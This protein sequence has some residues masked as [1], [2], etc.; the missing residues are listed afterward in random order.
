M[1]AHDAPT[2]LR[3]TSCSR[4]AFSLLQPLYF[5]LYSSLLKNWQNM[6]DNEQKERDFCLL[7]EHFSST[8]LVRWGVEWGHEPWRAFARVGLQLENGN[9]FSFS[10]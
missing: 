10:S 6:T 3:G 8:G 9:T 7:E 1:D 5:V 4:G 2:R